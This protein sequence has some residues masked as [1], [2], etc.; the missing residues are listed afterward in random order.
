MTA[1]TATATGPAAGCLVRFRERR[2]AASAT[3]ARAADVPDHARC[4][5]ARVAIGALASAA[6]AVL[7]VARN[8]DDAVRSRLE[9][10]ALAT[11]P[12][13]AS[14]IAFRTRVVGALYR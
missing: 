7:A 9:P 14:N 5:I 13:A 1:A 4:A 2:P 12:V 3:A 11:D 10:I 8:R 6:R